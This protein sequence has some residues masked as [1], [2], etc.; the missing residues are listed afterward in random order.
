TIEEEHCDDESLFL[1]L[2]LYC[3]SELVAC[4]RLSIQK[5]IAHI[6]R[7]AVRRE[8][9]KRGFGSIMMKHAHDYARMKGCT[10][11]EISAQISAFDFYKKL[12]Y[13]QFGDK[14]LD[15]RIL[16]IDMSLDL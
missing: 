2:N 4:C 5:D 12:G 11:V 15:A 7:V 13:V 16:H 6:G 14:Y 8:Y 1:H 3:D 10:S 9:R